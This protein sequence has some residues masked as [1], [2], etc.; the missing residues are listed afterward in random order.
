M[1]LIGKWYVCMHGL[2]WGRVSLGYGEEVLT[3][4]VRSVRAGRLLSATLVALL[5]TLAVQ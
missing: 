3:V 1:R 4:G 5:Q 2:V